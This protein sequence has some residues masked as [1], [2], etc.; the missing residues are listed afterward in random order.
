MTCP[1]SHCKVVVSLA[2]A[3]SC[4]A[5]CTSPRIQ[6]PPTLVLSGVQSSAPHLCP[7]DLTFPSLIRLSFSYG[8]Q[9]ASSKEWFSRSLS[10][11]P[12]PRAT[13]VLRS[14]RIHWGHYNMGVMCYQSLNPASATNQLRDLVKY[15]DN[16]W[17]YTQYKLLQS[18][19]SIIQ[20]GRVLWPNH[21]HTVPSDSPH[22]PLLPPHRAEFPVSPSLYWH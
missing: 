17:H 4:S 12:V 5:P 7:E 15:L 9:P 22:S 14:L 16:V 1:Q 8:L 20:F 19:S 11:I 21:V 6:Q 13:R 18:S 10:H 3:Q 2:K